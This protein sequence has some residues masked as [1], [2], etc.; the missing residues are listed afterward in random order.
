MSNLPIIIGLIITGITGFVFIETKDPPPLFY[1]LVNKLDYTNIAIFF[2]LFVLMLG[3]FGPL[4]LG[5][6]ISI[7]FF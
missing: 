3:V 1:W 6:V 4:I 7:Y 5:T 2:V